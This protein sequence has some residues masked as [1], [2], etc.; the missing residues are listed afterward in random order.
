MMTLAIVVGMLPTFFVSPLGGVLADR[1]NR[2]YLIN[3]ADG[4][5]AL[6]T[7]VLAVC[8]FLGQRNIALIF[9][10]M[11]I[12]AV[13][14]GIQTPAVNAVIPQITPEKHL[15]RV[16]GINTTIQSASMIISPMLSGAL[17][18]FT[19]I[20]YIFFIDV[21]TA[22]AGISI[23]FFFVKIPTIKREDARAKNI[24]FIKDV[25]IKDLK[26][27][28]SYILHHKFIKRFCAI[29]VFFFI[30]ASPMCLLTPLQVTRKFGVEVW[31]LT[32]M[33]VAFSG[34][35]LAG[36]ILMTI[37]GGFKNRT[38]TMFISSAALGI[39]SV[40][41]GLVTN[42]WTY[43]SCAAVMGFLMPVFN[44]PSMSILQSTVEE[45]YMGRVFGVFSMLSSVMMPVGMI[46]FGPLADIISIDTLLIICGSF[47]FII[48]FYFA[49]DKTMRRAGL[50]RQ[51]K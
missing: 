38:F 26:E 50:V 21:F 11:A 33:E 49:L 1:F 35:M 30:A 36:G 18:A 48:S 6:A 22:V 4:V 19:S 23:L 5:T 7:L 45:N 24:S 37:W 8:F 31:R 20:E 32:A 9:I 15:M 2:K 3:I 47:V 43:I 42:F 39:F 13:S 12:R 14:Q 40:L 27:G 34:G 17:L 16:N 46:F 10:I 25:F 44:V 28:F 41:L 51:E 29:A